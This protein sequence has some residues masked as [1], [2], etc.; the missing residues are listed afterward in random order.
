MK[1]FLVLLGC[2]VAVLG[3]YGA[4]LAVRAQSTP[5]TEDHIQRIKANCVDAQSVLTQLHASDALLR[6]NRGQLYESISSKLMAPFNSRVALNKF[7]GSKL[8]E[9]SAAYENQLND[10]RS[11]YK[12]YEESMSKTLRINCTNEPVAF[13]D[14]VADARAKRQQVHQT[15]IALQKTIQNYKTEFENFA[16]QLAKDKQ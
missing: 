12:A 9:Q 4:S 3:V 8:L 2:S 13:Y 5:M 15:I 6:V 11:S 14:S 7:D 10:F 16:A 1:K